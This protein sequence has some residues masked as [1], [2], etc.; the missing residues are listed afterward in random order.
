MSFA[1]ARAYALRHALRLLARRPATALLAVVLCAGALTLP[2]LA[3]TLVA[4]LRPL[5]AQI[6]TAPELSVFV[7]AAA[8]S[9]E[10]KSLQARIEA[11]P[12][13][14]QVQHVSRD[15]ALTELAQR[16][17]LAA[18]IGEL[19][20]NPLPDVLIV[21]LANGTPPAAV[22]AAA[23]AIRKLP[24]VDLVQLDSAWYRKLAAIG[25]IGLVAGSIAGGLMLAL[26][27]LVLIGAVRLLATASEDES[28]VLRLAGADERFVARP[29]RYIGGLTLMFSAVLAIGAVALILRALNPELGELARLYGA[30]LAIP[31]LPP[32]LLAGIVAGAAL[33]GLVLGSFG[34]TAPRRP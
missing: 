17:G 19:K 23:A 33:T 25:R 9:Q 1:T 7:A 20:A 5:A 11:E 34:V 6:A 29:Y 4:G 27:A 14:A 2:L 16:S 24:R 30:Q 3:A 22:D 15:A 28:R 10:I 31:M 13:V 12:G 8:S 26:V 32:P 21:A 18:P